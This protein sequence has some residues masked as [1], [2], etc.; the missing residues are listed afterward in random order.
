MKTHTKKSA[1]GRLAAQLVLRSTQARRII[2]RLHPLFNNGVDSLAFA[3]WQKD[4]FPGARLPA[5][6]RRAEIELLVSRHRSNWMRWA[7]SG[8]VIQA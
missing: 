2:D 4:R 1:H 8:P 7:F 3:A 5:F 6:R